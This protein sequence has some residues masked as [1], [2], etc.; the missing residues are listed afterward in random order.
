MKRFSIIAGVLIAVLGATA[1]Q[2]AIQLPIF[3]ARKG[4]IQN[5]WV[6]PAPLIP[7]T[8]VTCRVAVS[9]DVR[10]EKA[11]KRRLG[12]T[13]ILKL[14]W[15]DPPIAGTATST[16]HTESIGTLP[17]GLYTIL[18][19]SSHNGRLMDTKQVMFRVDEAPA[20]ALNYID[21]VWIEPE[22][23]LTQDPVTLHVSGEW[24][25]PGFSLVGLTT[26]LVGNKIAVKMY[27][28]SPV[29]NVLQVVTPYERKIEFTPL[30]EDTY[31][32][33]VYCYRDNR[34]VDQAQMT[35]AVGPDETGM[36]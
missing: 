25:T 3:P 20:S 12:S 7:T 28:N 8:D 15:I 22:H 14:Y 17:P 26:M 10:L 29:G 13:F 4:V 34:L 9:N 21:R 1:A 16:E 27:W 31:T 33:T 24:G 36:E 18:V 30:Y 32:A 6:E 2:T 23:P 19:Q 11:E 35:F 5:V